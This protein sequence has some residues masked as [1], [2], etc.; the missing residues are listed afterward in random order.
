MPAF[1]SG[2]VPTEPVTVPCVCDGQP[3]EQDTVTI[4]TRF[5]GTD[6]SVIDSAKIRVVDYSTS[7]VAIDLGQA[8]RA[9]MTLGVVG[10][11]FTDESGTAIPFDSKRTNDMDAAAWAPV[12]ER[13]SEVLEVSQA[14]LAKKSSA[15][16][17]KR[18]A[19]A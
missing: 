15:T 2:S 16:S 12:C 5:S 1:L 17:A 19:A 13:L 3:H 10:W 9:L 14:P 6:I 18:R 4:R 8:N 7:E 11:S